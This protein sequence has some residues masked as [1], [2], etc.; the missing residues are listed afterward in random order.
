MKE[1]LQEF[2]S[3][4]YLRTKSNCYKR[5]THLLIFEDGLDMQNKFESV[6]CSQQKYQIFFQLKIVKKF[7]VELDLIQPKEFYVQF[8]STISLLLSVICLI[9]TTISDLLAYAITLYF[10]KCSLFVLVNPLMQILTH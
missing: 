7:E 5:K 6:L 9:F 2:I 1:H 8:E 3:V 4:L 10:P